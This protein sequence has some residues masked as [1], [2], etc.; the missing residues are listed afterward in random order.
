MAKSPK[1]CTIKFGANRSNYKVGGRA[2]N[3]TAE[4]A[5]DLQS[6]LTAYPATILD[7]YYGIE[8]Q[9]TIALEGV[10]RETEQKYLYTQINHHIEQ[11]ISEWDSFTEY[12]IYGLAKEVNGSKIYMSVQNLNT[13][14]VL[15]NASWWV[16]VC[17]TATLNSQITSITTSITTLNGQVSTLNTQ[18]TTLNGQ[19][20]TL[21]TQVTTLNGQVS[22]LNTQVT[23]L[24]GQVSTIN[25]QISTLDANFF[26]L[27]NLWRTGDYKYS[28]VTIDHSF[29]LL[30]DGRAISRST[31]STLFSVI[32][33][34][35]GAGNGSTTFN[36]PDGR[37]RAIGI[38]GQGSGL[39][40]RPIGTLTGTETHTLTKDEMPSHK[41]SITLSHELNGGKD[42][43]GYPAVD[44][45]G[46]LV[47]HAETQP[48][49][50]ISINTGVGNPLGSTGGGLAHNNMQPTFFG[51]NLFIHY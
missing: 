30:C 14:H 48:D 50:S 26:T 43:Y 5:L 11:G 8:K 23:T 49:N 40:N 25:S 41:H 47:T 6:A 1:L 34:T 15:T 38:A 10:E 33:T 18:V 16:L 22:T 45:T 24:N 12:P 20:S 36:L 46:P 21:N 39:T 2:V 44:I 35:F 29:W 51:G 3:N 42:D 9:G 17:D 4:L 32:G 31:Y 27:Y 13:N 37:G 7:G 28:A 19:V